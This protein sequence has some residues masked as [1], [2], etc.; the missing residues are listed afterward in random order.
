[1]NQKQADIKR[2]RE[3]GEDAARRF[4]RALDPRIR[5][6]VR[7]LHDHNQWPT[8]SKEI[9]EEKTVEVR[10][11]L[12]RR[13]V[14]RKQVEKR[15]VVEPSTV[16]LGYLEHVVSTLTHTYSLRIFPNKE[17]TFLRFGVDEWPSTPDIYPIVHRTE[18]GTQVDD[19]GELVRPPAGNRIGIEPAFDLDAAINKFIKEMASY[20]IERG[21]PLPQD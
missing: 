6:F 4:V 18:A 16:Y 19:H 1:M 12:F 17:W 11:G 9:T 7:T 10:K 5:Q 13:P 3:A 20:L 21:L 14:S 8:V 15:T 2:L